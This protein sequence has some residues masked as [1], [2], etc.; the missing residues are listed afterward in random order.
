MSNMTKQVILVGMEQ[1]RE[2]RENQ[3]AYPI[4]LRNEWDRMHGLAQL[5]RDG[6]AYIVRSA[7][8]IRYTHIRREQ[9]R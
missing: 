7:N 1:E 6:K 8:G 3:K 9:H 4:A 5:I 2:D